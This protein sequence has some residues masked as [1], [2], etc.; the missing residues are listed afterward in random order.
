MP[1]RSKTERYPTWFQQKS[2]TRTEETQKRMMFSQTAA[3]NFGKCTNFQ[4][5]QGSRIE[6]ILFRHRLHTRLR[7]TT[8]SV[9]DKGCRKIYESDTLGNRSGLGM[10]RFCEVSICFWDSSIFFSFKSTYQSWCKS[11]H[12]FCRNSIAFQLRPATWQNSV[13]MITSKS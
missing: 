7:Q 5:T 11:S 2:Q 3:R 13:P 12:D 6:G 4:N 10:R 9:R 8:A 1:P